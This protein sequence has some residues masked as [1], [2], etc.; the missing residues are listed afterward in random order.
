MTFLYLNSDKMG[1]GDPELGRKL[2]K[3]FLKTLLESG[4]KIDMIG[5]VNNL[6]LSEFFSG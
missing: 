3:V 4:E 5:C 6:V 2:M 1:D